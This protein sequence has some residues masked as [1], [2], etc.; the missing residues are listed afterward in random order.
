VGE[1]LQWTSA[2]TG[3]VISAPSKLGLGP[4][5]GTLSMHDA[6]S[7]TSPSEHSLY[8]RKFQYM[9]SLNGKSLALEN[10]YAKTRNDPS[11]KK[12][13]S[14]IRALN[15]HKQHFHKTKCI[16]KNKTKTKTRS[17]NAL[18]AN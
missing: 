16:Q 15:F 1:V 14:A 13:M 2:R 11:T 9:F 3:I 18:I 7:G 6:A 8:D 10:I 5:G 17:I 12:E 4:D